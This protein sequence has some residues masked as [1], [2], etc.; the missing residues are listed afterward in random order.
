MNKVNND[1]KSNSDDI[2]S[3]KTKQEEINTFINELQSHVILDKHFVD[4]DNNFGIV[5]A[6][7]IVYYIYFNVIFIYMFMHIEFFQK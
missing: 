5:I 6:N 4:P 2:N 7:I 1:I 3:N